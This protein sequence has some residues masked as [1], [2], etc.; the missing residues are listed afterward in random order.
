MSSAQVGALL[1]YIHRTSTAARDGDAPDHELLERFAASQDG[2]A[3]A[4]LLKRHGSMV[5][6]VCRSVL[7]DHH[8]AEDAFQAAFLVLAR[9]AGS[10]HR[11]EAVSA[12][13]YR[14][15]YHL[16]VKARAS[17]ARRRSHE[18]RAVVTPPGDP[19]PDVSLRELRGI[20]NEELESLPEQYRAP[21]IL[22]C[23]EEK[24]LEEA[25]R[26][27]GWT[28]GAVKGR[29]QRGRERLRQRLRRRGLEVTAGLLA[30][31]ATDSASAQVSAAL[32]A[33]T[34][35]A[36]LRIAAGEGLAAGVVS[37]NVAALV[38]GASRAMFFSKTRIVTLLVLAIG[39][40]AAGLGA[41]SHRG[42]R[43][44]QAAPAPQ[45]GTPPAPAAKPA[46]DS[47]TLHGRVLDPD[48]KPCAGVKLYAPTP[49]G[50]KTPAVSATSGEDGRF[51]LTI[52]LGGPNPTTRQVV[53]AASGFGSDWVTVGKAEAGREVTLRLVK[54][55]PIRGRILDRDG[56]PVAGAKVRVLGVEA[57]PGE[58]LTKMLEQTRIQGGSGGAVKQWNGPLPGQAGVVTTGA[59][60]RFRLAGFG[61]ERT[62]RLQVEGPTIEYTMITVMTRPG[63]AVVGPP[64]PKGFRRAKVHPAAFDYLAEPSRPIRGVVRDKATGK[65]VAG[66]TLWSY[67]TTHR[68]RTDR[69]GRYEMLGCPKAAAY[70]LYLEPPDGRHFRIQVQINDTP[71]FE[72]LAADI[73]LPAGIP[74]RG[75]VRDK[76]TGKPVA[77]VRISYYV[78]FP[79]LKAGRL[80]DY[81]EYEGLGIAQSGADGAFAITVLPGPG[82]IAAAAQPLSSYRTALVTRRELEDLLEKRPD[83]INS[84]AILVIHGTGTLVNAG[85]SLL[86]QSR[87]NTLALIKPDDK[88][89]ELVR[90]LVLLPALERRGKVV[91]ADGKPVSDVH[92]IGL[93]PSPAG[94]GWSTTL[95]SASFT[96]RGLHPG[97]PRFLY[98]HHAEKNLGCTLELRGEKTEPLEVRLLPCGSVSG[99]LVDK[100]GK[101]VA[102]TVIHFCREG[103]VAFWPGGFQVKTDREGRFRADGLVSGQ[104]YTMNRNIDNIADTLPSG[105]VVEPGQR[106]DLGDLAVEVRE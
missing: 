15:A 17:A 11:R 38:Q 83:R 18:K 5:L 104:K 14:V 79:N 33:S 69:E 73:A 70:K 86:A 27:L 84:E 85:H 60:G 66:V 31:L 78:L 102:N 41:L 96:V 55:V 93:E 92:I 12:W 99:R 63:D 6:G 95:K 57:F 2:A 58:D 54:D 88:D 51:E 62:V 68:P 101:P 82:V 39:I 26:V 9:K 52:P 45:Q 3:F 49:D 75:R 24:S 25:A 106:K 29:L 74:V 76:A 89:T 7:H 81:E 37:G 13:L 28:K 59:D 40:S 46:T 19:V 77:G 1:R 48:G 91:D 103:Y 23:L 56:K 32:A 8:D 50:G 53:A 65:P 30:A 61:R 44:Q 100:A 4:L 22:C 35:R 36:A 64:M 10:I 47:V 94:P 21:L 97:R 42:L 72:P 34:L 67:L 98:F 90:D 20:L 71:G 87:Y 16:A 105:V 43:A 80:E